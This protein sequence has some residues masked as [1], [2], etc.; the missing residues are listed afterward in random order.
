MRGDRLVDGVELVVAGHL[1]G[2]RRAPSDL[3]DDEVADQVEEAPLVED[4][5][6][7][8]LQLGRALRGEVIARRWSARA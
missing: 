5:L 6:D 8:H 3:E 2:D 4:A 7:Q 1:L